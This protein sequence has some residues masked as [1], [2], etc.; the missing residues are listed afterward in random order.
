M[1]VL[2][3]PPLWAVVWSVTPGRESEYNRG[4]Q[5]DVLIFFLRFMFFII[6]LAAQVCGGKWGFL[7]VAGELFVE[8]YGT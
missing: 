2:L 4:A 5:S 8:A 7:D 3:D 6:Y 1:I